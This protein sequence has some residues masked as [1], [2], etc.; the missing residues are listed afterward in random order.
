MDNSLNEKFPELAAQWHPTKN[1]NLLPENVSYGC[2]KAVWWQYPYDDPETGKHFDFVWKATVNSRS[3]GAGCPYLANRAVWTGFNDLATTNPEL[4]REWDYENNGALTPQS[5]S[6]NSHKKVSWIRPYNDPDTG[7][8]YKFRWRTTV[9]NRS[10]KGHSCPYLSGKAVWPGFNDLATTNPELAKEW[11]YEKNGSLT[12]QSV[13]AYSGKIVSWVRP[14]DDPKT[15]KHY[16]FRWEASIYDRSRKESGC[17][18]L[19][20]RAAWP[21]FNDLA[22]T[23]PELAKEWDYENNGSLTPQSVTAYSSKLES[24]ICP[25]DDPKTGK[26]YIFKWNA[27]VYSRSEGLGCPYLS[28]RAAWPGFNDLAT[29]NP[30]LTKEWDYENNGSLTPQSVTAYSGKIVSWIYPYRH[31]ITDAHFV[32]RWKATVS[33]RSEG[34][35]C[36]YLSNKLVWP[37]FN[38]LK[39]VF[40]EIAAEWH[41]LINRQ[42]PEN[43]YKYANR[44]VAWLC[45]VCRNPYI[46]SVRKRTLEGTGCPRCK[47]HRFKN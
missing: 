9:N 27:A 30:A 3:R 37:G 2:K 36:P 22:T 41:P 24:W 21:G 40:P 38:D 15:D 10:N 43:T 14:Y 25:Y 20:G 13:T 47:M 33:S 28:G 19:T 17:P 44:K 18:Y 4:A 1:G 12:P 46:A 7:K 42:P 39:T 34:R 16:D 31:P 32:F 26:H 29:T 6:A 35:G 23:N 8:H 11:D 45:P 5:I